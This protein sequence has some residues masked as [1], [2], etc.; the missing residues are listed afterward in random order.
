MA[1][2]AN[3]K[4]KILYLKQILESE[5]DDT[6]GMTLAQIAEALHARGVDVERKTLYDDLTVLRE[7]GMDIEMR[8]RDGEVRY[9]VVSRDFELPELKLLVDAVQ[10]SKFVTRKKSLD[11]IKKLEGLTSRHSAQ[12]LR[13][14]VY[15]TNRIK[16]MN[17]S[18][19]Y[20]VDEL[21]EAIT[22]N[23]K[24]SFLYFE[25]DESKNK[26]L[27]RNGE[28]YKIS[29]FALNWDDENYYLIGYDSEVGRIKH[30]RVDKM[31][32]IRIEDEKR[33][34]AEHFRNFDMALYSRKTFGMYGGCEENVTLRCHRK[35]AGVIIDRFGRETSFLKSGDEHFEIHVKVSLS[36]TFYAWLATFSGD[37]E[38]KAPASARREYVAFLQKSLDHYKITT[39]Q[40]EDQAHDSS[41]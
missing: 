38:M 15:V 5:T 26:R 23:A 28:R 30:Y 29:P 4:I 20:A 39:T 12:T 41:L 18:I 11:L 33:D 19:Y 6:H 32:Q 34:G 7:S 2:G 13:R 40:R 17:E 37:I 10:S 25:W 14:Q 16:T 21:H 8:K 9:H 24:I 27:R 31:L 35:L 22:Q 36:P 1:K 3:Q